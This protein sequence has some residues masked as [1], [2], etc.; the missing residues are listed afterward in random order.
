VKRAPHSP[1][2]SL[3]DFSLSRH[4]DIARKGLEQIMLA[5]FR[6]LLPSRV[7]RGCGGH[8][9]RLA[10]I[11]RSK[12]DAASQAGINILPSRNKHSTESTIFAE[13]GCG[14][15]L[16]SPLRLKVDICAAKTR[17]SASPPKADMCGANRHVCCGPKA[18]IAELTASTDH[19]RKSSGHRVLTASRI[20]V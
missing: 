13:R 9:V 5:G 19:Q 15:D 18:D 14:S 20:G 1:G 4:E 11:G 10:M 2:C 8:R 16:K 3:R 17:M 12:K 6:L 7:R